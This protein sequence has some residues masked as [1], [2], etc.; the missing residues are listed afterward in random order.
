[1]SSASESSSEEV[2]ELQH[3]IEEI[4]IMDPKPRRQGME[5]HQDSVSDLPPHL[6]T[7]P[8]VSYL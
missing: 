4:A 5:T 8:P 1:L 6:L 7:D 3:T 2:D